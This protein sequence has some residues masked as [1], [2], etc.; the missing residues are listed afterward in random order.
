[1]QFDSLLGFRDFYP[2]SCSFRNYI[3]DHWRDVAR[4]FNFLEYDAPVLKS[5]DLYIEKSGE[6]IVSQLFNFQDLGGREVALRPEMTPSLARLVGAKG[7]SLKRPIK[8][9]NIGETIVMNDLKRV[10]FAPSTSSMP[11]FLES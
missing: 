9:F 4:S 1:M 6:E 11:I 10:A 7:N 2:E 3:F 8:W 5:L